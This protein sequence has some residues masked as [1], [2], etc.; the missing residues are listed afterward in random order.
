MIHSIESGG[1]TVKISDHG[2]ELQS[3]FLKDA[4]CDCG[5]GTEFLWDGDPTHWTSRAPV[6]FPIVG[7]VINDEYRVDGKTYRLGG[8][9]FASRMDY[10]VASA[11][12]N[13]ITFVLK[14]GEKTLAVYPY[15]F[16]LKVSYSVGN[17]ALV[18]TYEV[19]NTNDTTMHFSV[20]AHPGFMCPID[21]ANESFDDYY[22]EF[23][24]NETIGR[25][26]MVAGGAVTV[27]TV[28]FFDDTNILP[29]KPDLFKTDA[30]IFSN[31]KSSGVNLKSKKSKK[32]VR[33]EFPGFS[34]LGIW[35]RAGSPYV[36]IEPWFGVNDPPDFTGELKDKPGIV[37]LAAGKTFSCTHTIYF[38]NE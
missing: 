8:H 2:A 22:L 1:L 23:D 5:C 35:T 10:E 24:K 3:A 18:T 19:V 31:L 16:E 17:R 38:Y 33:M 36:C 6:L 34:Y 15:K 37:R 25:H 27:E 4:N 30:L 13:A 20:G 32:Y 7:R 9:G 12:K 29:L 26:P 14:S 21:R 28:P 11:S